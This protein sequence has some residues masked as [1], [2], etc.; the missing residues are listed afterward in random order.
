MR[1][2]M[3]RITLPSVKTTTRVPTGL[4]VSRNIASRPAGHQYSFIPCLRLPD[5][6][7]FSEGSA[8]HKLVKILAPLGNSTSFGCLS[9][10]IE[11]G[12]VA[13][14]A[15]RTVNNEGVYHRVPTPRAPPPPFLPSSTH[16]KAGRSH[17]NEEITPLLPSPHWN[18]RAKLPNHIKI[19]TCSALAPM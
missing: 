14:Q 6:G 7:S 18:R 2:G 9:F 17:L 5:F 13:H 1:S 10:L 19:R 8:S 3:P 16:W 4:H 15:R 12:A 11:K